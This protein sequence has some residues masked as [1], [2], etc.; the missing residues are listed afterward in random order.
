V[1]HL[2]KVRPD[3]PVIV[4][5]GTTGGSVMEA[6][7]HLGARA[8]LRKPVDPDELLAAVRPLLGR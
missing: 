3:V 1:R 6:A 5:S 2:K 8:M 4:I 7:A